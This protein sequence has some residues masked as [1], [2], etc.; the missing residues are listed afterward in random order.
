MFTGSVWPYWLY[1]DLCAFRPHAFRNR[2][3]GRVLAGGMV[4]VLHL[5]LAIHV[6]YVMG[7]YVKMCVCAHVTAADSVPAAPT[8]ALSDDF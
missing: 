8:A 5:F 6:V 2:W 4:I 7:Q 1:A 3:K